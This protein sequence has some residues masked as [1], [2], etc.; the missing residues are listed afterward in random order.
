MPLFGHNKKVVSATFFHHLCVRHP[1][2]P[3]AYPEIGT[4][5][6]RLRS[7]LSAVIVLTALV[8]A[9]N[10]AASFPNLLGYA[11]DDYGLSMYKT[12]LLPIYPD[13]L[14][15]CSKKLVGYIKRSSNS[16]VLQPTPCYAPRT[17]DSSRQGHLQSVATIQ[18][19]NVQ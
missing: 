4:S 12:Y 18:A 5:M 19:Q 13:S 17:R 14:S 15:G 11:T 1:E 3:D 10:I 2:V 6:S 7:L 16:Y 8:D 9:D